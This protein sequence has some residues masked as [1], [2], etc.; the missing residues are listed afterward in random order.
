[1]S[2]NRSIKFDRVKDIAM[3]NIEAIL[4]N[5]VRNNYKDDSIISYTIGFIGSIKALCDGKF[6]RAGKVSILLRDKV[7][8]FI[9]GLDIRCIGELLEVLP[10]RIDERLPAWL[11]KGAVPCLDEDGWVLVPST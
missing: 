1:M 5:I 10:S 3:G 7:K 4:N 9:R 6:I 2:S 8:E 11:Y